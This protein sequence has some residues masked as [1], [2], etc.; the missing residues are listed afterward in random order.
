MPWVIHVGSLVVIENK[1][2]INSSHP[3]CQPT[4][5]WPETNPVRQMGTRPYLRPATVAK[6]LDT[7]KT[8]LQ[9]WR[10]QGLGPPYVKLNGS[11]GGVVRYP[12]DQ[13]AEWESSQ[14]GESR[15]EKN[16][17]K[18]DQYPPVQKRSI[19]RQNRGHPMICLVHDCQPRCTHAG[20][21]SLRASVAAPGSQRAAHVSALQKPV[22]EPAA[23]TRLAGAL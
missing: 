6:I 2:K 17:G 9:R 11:T 4:S 20:V 14:R 3:S 7:T 12:S 15:Q 10:I 22:L 18:A 23:R 5:G 21:Q 19:S 13:L 1:G 8:T 16:K